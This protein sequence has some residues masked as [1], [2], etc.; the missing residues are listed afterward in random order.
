MS[1][2]EVSNSGQFVATIILWPAS[3]TSNPTL[4]P[5]VHELSIEDTSG[6]GSSVD[7]TIPEPTVTVTP[8]V[9]GPRDYIT[10]VGENWPVDNPENPSSVSIE[11]EVDDNPGAN[12]A[13]TYILFAD[14]VGRVTQEHRVHRNVAIPSTIQ[15]KMTHAEVAEIGPSRCRPPPSRSPPAKH[16]LAT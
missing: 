1:G 4:I 15:V 5:G 9:A 14:A 11:V 12:R 10:I 3:G 13:R 6:F 7:I 2:V 8:D 16:S